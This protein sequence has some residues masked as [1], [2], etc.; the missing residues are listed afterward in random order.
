MGLV[1]GELE[2][3]RRRAA[4]RSPPR[5]P[6]DEVEVDLLVVERDD[7]AALGEGAE[8]GVDERRADE[9]L[10]G[11]GAGGVVG[12]LGQDGHGQAERA[13]GLA[14]H[15]RQLARPDEPD[16][17]GAQVARPR[18][19]IRIDRGPDTVGRLREGARRTMA[20]P[21]RI[22]GVLDVEQPLPG[23]VAQLQRFEEAGFAH[24]F[25]SQ[26]F[27]PDA[28]TLLAVAGAQVPGSGWA[29][30][31][32]PCYPRHPM[33][34]AQ[35]AL[36]VQAATG[37]RL[38]LGIG[39]SHQVVVEG[40]WGLSFDGPLAYMRE[41]L[42]SLHAA[43]AGRDG[44]ERG[45]AGDHERVRPGRHPP[46]ARR[47]PC[48]SPR[49]GRRC[50]GWRARSPTGTITWMTGTTTIRGHIAPTINAAAAAGRAGRRHAWSWR[51]RSWSPPT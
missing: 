2:R 37:D 49:W 22:G 3:R 48:W 16:V 39:L 42:A 15:A 28:L 29:R 7:G 5:Q 33:M 38:L 24:A 46:E 8:V 36:T 9:D 19:G 14:R 21:L 51:C 23:I 43:A 31:S 13:G 12:L 10:G 11:D 27:G 47:R 26:I 35:Q 45:G 32:C 6:G 25:A 17:V 44:V 50:C 34:L 18:R 40:M 20:K 1:D 4:G 41:Y 30:A